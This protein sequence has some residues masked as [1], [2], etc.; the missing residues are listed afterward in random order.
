M[1]QITLRQQ[2]KRLVFLLIPVTLFAIAMGFLESAV[3]VYLREIYYPEGFSFPLKNLEAPVTYTEFF[4]EVATLVMLVSVAWLIARAWIVRFA[5]FIYLFAI[6]D[7]FYYI[8]LWLL[9]GWPESLLTWDI[10]F[11]IP[12]IW[13]GP[14]L[15]PVINSCTMILL[16]MVIIRAGIRHEQVRLTGLAW[17]FLIAGALITILAYIQGYSRY[18][19]EQ[20][21]LAEWVGS[22]NQTEVMAHA[23]R[24]VPG[25]FNWLLFLTGTGLFVLAILQVIRRNFTGFNKD[26]V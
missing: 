18:M 2:N 12:T 24:Y 15:A 8:F 16:A 13:V 3:V 4:R 6:W 25:D 5:W 1:K 26:R 20:F 22:S 19:Q 23:A 10:L 7:I 21:S 17:G 14:V 9:L 11:L